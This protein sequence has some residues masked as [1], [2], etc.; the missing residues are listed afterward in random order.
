MGFSS[1]KII[2][3]ER[4]TIWNGKHALLPPKWYARR[5]NKPT[6]T[7]LLLL[8]KANSWSET[9]ILFRSNETPLNL[10]T[11]FAPPIS[12]PFVGCERTKKKQSSCV[13]VMWVLTRNGNAKT[14]LRPL[15]NANQLFLS[16]LSFTATTTGDDD[17]LLVHHL[18]SNLHI[19]LSSTFHYKK[20]DTV[21]QRGK[22]QLETVFR[23]RCGGDIAI[24]VR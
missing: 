8:C 11:R 1:P 19:A 14:F 9:K 6:T 7:Y 20:Y 22:P 16:F 3:G 10:L 13:C 2:T 23:A 24:T 17:D 21:S 12:T 5:D 15:T 18:S 4:G